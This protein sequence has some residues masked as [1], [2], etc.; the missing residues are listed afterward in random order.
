MLRTAELVQHVAHLIE[1][2]DAHHFALDDDDAALAVDRDA[3]RMLQHVGS[4][5]ASKLA[6]LVVDLDLVGRRPLRHD[7]VARSLD[8]GH[9]VRVQQLTVALS[10][11]AKLELEAALLV[12]DLDAVV[13]GVGHDDVVLSVDGHARWLC[14]LTFHDAKLAKLAMINH[15]LALDLRARRIQRRRRHQ[16][17]QIKERRIVAQ[18]GQRSVVHQSTASA[19]S[20]AASVSIA[21]RRHL[22]RLESARSGVGAPFFVRLRLRQVQSGCS[23]CQSERVV[24]A[25]HRAE[26]VGRIREAFRHEMRVVVMRR[27][28]RC[29]SHN[30]AG[31][32]SSAVQSQVDT[33]VVAQEH[34]TVGPSD[35]RLLGLG[36]AEILLLLLPVDRSVVFDVAVSVAHASLDGLVI[37]DELDFGDALQVV[38]AGRRAVGE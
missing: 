31:T 13:V 1:N 16:L 37:R 17:R 18:T 29:R 4:E 24:E 22:E 14:E 27:R 28:L 33:R 20:A 6:V 23:Q 34:R 21:Q 3:A 2:D 7:N 36:R 15:L 9:A 10:A 12:E 25:Q 11:L 5:F 26:A 38:I 35:G 32:K 30:R 8:H 19:T